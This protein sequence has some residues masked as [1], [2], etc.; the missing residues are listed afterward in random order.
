[1]YGHRGTGKT[2][3]ALWLAASHVR[4]NGGLILWVSAE[5]SDERMA[6]RLDEI[7]QEAAGESI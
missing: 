4:R 7:G 6:A 2:W 5:M 3:I 1:M